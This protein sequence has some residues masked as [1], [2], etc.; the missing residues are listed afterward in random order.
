MNIKLT[1][2][3]NEGRIFFDCLFLLVTYITITHTLTKTEYANWSNFLFAI[4]CF[5]LTVILVVWAIN[6]FKSFTNDVTL[7]GINQ[8]FY[9][10]WK[11]DN[12]D[13][14]VEEIKSS[15]LITVLGY[16]VSILTG[17][18]FYL[19]LIMLLV[20]VVNIGK[21]IATSEQW[22]NQWIVRYI[23]NY[24][25]SKATK[26][27]I[28]NE[29]TSVII[30][31]G[32]DNPKYRDLVISSVIYEI[33]NDLSNQEELSEEEELLLNKIFDG[34]IFTV[35]GMTFE[36]NIEMLLSISESC[37]KER[38]DNITNLLMAYTLLDQA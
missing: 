11:Q 5:E 3:V 28:Y 7:E 22:N 6:K 37:G 2:H 17:S 35:Y 33:V 20:V 27:A 18:Y 24:L 14:F 23:T 21:L 10:I 1:K 38:I 32:I 16:A 30:N 25:G 31:F 13:K 12:R 15:L 4:G 36:K 8:I 19:I 26:D 29:L 9:L 34:S